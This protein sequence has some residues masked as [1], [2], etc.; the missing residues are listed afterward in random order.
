MSRAV[1]NAVAAS[2]TDAASGR[3]AAA[4][5]CGTSAV[6][7]LM[8]GSSAPRGSPCFNR[9]KLRYI[10]RQFVRSSDVC[11]PFPATKAVALCLRIMPH[12]AHRRDARML[13]QMVLA[14][15][16]SA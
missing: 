4:L 6:P 3:W 15:C 10:L 2:K 16:Y 8:P 9:D 11:A 12:C 1:S 7:S 5:G 13:K 14:R